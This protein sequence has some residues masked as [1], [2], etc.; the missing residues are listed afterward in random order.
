MKNARLIQTYLP[1]GTLEGVR[2]IEPT[3]STIKALVAPRLSINNL[4]ARIESGQ[5]AIYILYSNTDGTCYIGE[6]EKGLSRV[7]RHAKTKDFWDICVLFVSKDNSLEKGDVKYL[8]SLL[9]EKAKST[10]SVKVLNATAPPKNTIHEFKTHVLDSIVE[11][12]A[13]I[14]KFLGYSV[15]EAK[16]VEPETSQEEIWY[17]T[18]KKTIASAMYKGDKFVVLGSSTIDRSYTK[19]WADSSPGRVTERERLLRENGATRGDVVEL[20]QNV[21]F[22]SP[23][24][25][26]QFVTGRSIN[27]WKA[28]KNQFGTTMDEVMRKGAE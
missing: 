15:L 6:S 12:V 16:K 4:S 2:I 23:N 14:M 3:Q 1:D 20:V 24:Q 17:C 26:A 8:E 9:I 19:S 27:A 5:P 28:W 11:D 13:L 7:T 18:S 10:A 21:S 22:S 25:A